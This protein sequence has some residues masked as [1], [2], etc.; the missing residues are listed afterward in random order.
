MYY[1]YKLSSILMLLCSISTF[2]LSDIQSDTATLYKYRIYCITEA[3]NVYQWAETPPTTCPNNTAHT[4]NPESISVIAVRAP[5]AV[6]I[7]QEN[8]PTGGNFMAESV[9][10]TIAPGPNVTTTIAPT[11]PFDIT[12]SNIS[13]TTTAAH[14]GDSISAQGANNITVGALAQDVIAGTTTL[15]VTQTVIDNTNI[16]YYVRLTDGVNIDNLGRVLA[17]DKTNN[18]LTVEIPTTQVF[19]AATPTVVQLSIYAIQ[20]FK[21]GPPTRYE[22]AKSKISGF[23]IPVGQ[24]T[25]FSYT[26]TTADPKTLVIDYEYF[27]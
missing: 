6:K 17:I 8:T 13:F 3:T 15:A 5:D 18:T 21:L 25:V 2:L 23:H 14:E 19:S 24:L 11:W 7:K 16:G 20:N 1:R 26:N 27:Y 22:L 10:I 9:T 12:L 4:I